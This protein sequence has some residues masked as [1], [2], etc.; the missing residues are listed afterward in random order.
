MSDVD[1]SGAGTGASSQPSGNA[2]GADLEAIVQ[3]AVTAALAGVD[4]RFSGFQSLMDKKLATLTRQLKTPGDSG[5][6]EG[7]PDDEEVSE[8]EE[9]RRT[10]A[11][12]E[13]AEK[14]PKEVALFKSVMGKGSLEEQLQAI[15]AFTAAMTPPAA[16][17]N[18]DADGS[19]GG[20][21]PAPEV[22]GNNPARPKLTLTGAIDSDEKADLILASTAG[23]RGFLHRINRNR[24]G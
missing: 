21:E 18:P 8:L 24:Q 16:D 6:P 3:K 19:E 5:D 4:A 13:F 15:S 10:V 11:L 20:D 22:D 9:L 12:Y 2:T 1:Q 23:Q 14:Y 7:Q 17:S